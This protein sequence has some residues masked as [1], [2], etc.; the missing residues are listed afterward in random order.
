MDNN[1]RQYE[2]MNQ[3]ENKK[4]KYRHTYLVAV[5]WA[6]VFFPVLVILL[7]IIFKISGTHA[8][9]AIL[10]MFIM[11]APV[12]IPTYLLINLFIIIWAYRK[13]KIVAGI[14]VKGKN[15]NTIMFTVSLFVV[16]AVSILV[17]LSMVYDFVLF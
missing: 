17:W 11:L 14:V 3:I 1:I 10:W 9:E 5:C 15:L 2:D 6:S 4:I 12:S 8:V 16:I 13:D 7:S